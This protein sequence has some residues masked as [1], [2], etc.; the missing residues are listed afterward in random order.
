[1]KFSV[2]TESA[3]AGSTLLSLVCFLL[4][5][6]E[7]DCYVHMYLQIRCNFY[8]YILIKYVSDH[9][10]FLTIVLSS[11]RM[12]YCF[13]N[14]L[15]RYLRVASFLWLKTFLS[16]SPMCTGRLCHNHVTVSYFFSL[17]HLA[18]AVSFFLM[19]ISLSSTLVGFFSFGCLRFCR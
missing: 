8:H 19:C 16:M 10:P 9:L 7:R 4:L 5:A 6:L 15:I 13:F 17:D 14:P 3:T 12:P 11:V 18:T 1:M 2:H